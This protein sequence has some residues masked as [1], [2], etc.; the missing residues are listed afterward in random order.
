M[1]VCIC[2][3]VSMCALSRSSKNLFGTP[4]EE[5]VNG[6]FSILVFQDLDW[7]LNLSKK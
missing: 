2:T 5:G 1:F 7:G 6:K 3:S 4:E